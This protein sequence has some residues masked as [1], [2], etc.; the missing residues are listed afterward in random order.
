MHKL[1]ERPIKRKDT[2]LSVDQYCRTSLQEG[3][4]KGVSVRY[5]PT[6]FVVEEAQ[7]GI[8]AAWVA[9]EQWHN[10]RFIA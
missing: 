5:M 3:R 7:G 2:F 9:P 8:C 6:T 1:M 10:W 4:L